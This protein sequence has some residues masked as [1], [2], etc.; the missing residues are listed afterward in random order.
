MIL[1]DDSLYITQYGISYGI[2]KNKES[3]FEYE[4]NGSLL[5]LF[6]QFSAIVRLDI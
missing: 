6:I 5:L 2:I 3:F 4:K 1:L